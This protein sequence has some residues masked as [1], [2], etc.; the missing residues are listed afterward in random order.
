MNTDGAKK[1]PG[2]IARQIDV[3]MQIRRRPGSAIG[4][5]GGWLLG[6]WQKKGAGFYGLGFVISFVILEIRSIIDDL[7]GDPATG[8]LMQGVEF[9]VRFGVESVING[10]LALVWPLFVLERLGAYGI[11]LLV[12]GYLVFERGLRPVVEHRF[13]EL[14]ETREL[15]ARKKQEKKQQKVMKKEI[16][17]TKK[18]SAR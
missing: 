6:L 3:A 5:F 17:K 4:L 9:L 10:V 18:C 14:R 13:P 16:K 7:T 8:L 15:I 1:K 11:V 2:R 12:G